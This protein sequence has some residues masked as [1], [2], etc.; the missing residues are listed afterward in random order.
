MYDVKVKFKAPL[1]V[2]LIWILHGRVMGPAWTT[3][4]MAVKLPTFITI[5][6]FSKLSFLL[7]FDRFIEGRPTTCKRKV[8]VRKKT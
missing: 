5:T 7:V 4:A 1:T 6:K 2:T 8:E 3:N